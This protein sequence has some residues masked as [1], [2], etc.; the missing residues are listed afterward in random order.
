MS[1]V[2]KI[3][4]ITTCLLLLLSSTIFAVDK[5]NLELNISQEE[6]KVGDKFTVTVDWEEGMQAADFALLYDNEKL[7]YIGSDLEDVFVSNNNNKLVVAWFS[8]NDTDKT[9]IE[10]KFKAIEEGKVAL[11]T[12]VDGG[13]ATGNLEQ[14]DEYEEA[15][16]TI[17]ILKGSRVSISTFA[18][19]ILFI[20]FLIFIINKKIKGGKRKWET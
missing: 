12:K 6:I 17:E 3:I 8:D 19:I 4:V 14:P 5:L 7:E 18:I 16:K 9:K 10:F 1:K 11:R 15:N 13:F 2:Y 20:I